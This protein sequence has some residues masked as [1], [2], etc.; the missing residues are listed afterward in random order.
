LVHGAFNA[1]SSWAGVIR[2]LAPDGLTVVAVAN[3]LRG[4]L[5]D[6]AYV[7]SVV[8]AIA[9]PVLLVGHS[10]GGAVITNAATRTPRVVGLVYVAAVAPDAGETIQALSAQ[11]PPTLLGPALRPATVAVDAAGATTTEFSI[12]RAGFQAVLAA[13]V[14]ADL[15]TVMAATQRPVA[16]AAFTDA[17]GPPAWKSLPS[18]FIVATDDQAVGADAERFFAQRAG[19]TTVEVA[20]SHSVE[21]SQPQAVAG[22]IRAAVAAVA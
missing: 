13:D 7:A 1:G 11:G 8:N 21:V 16:A 6:A 19:A 18:W 20:A 14:A 9:G 3:P 17:S 15:A 2:A 5:S 4:L 12:D 22:V 10:Y